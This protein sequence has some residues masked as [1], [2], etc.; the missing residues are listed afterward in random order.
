[1][2]SLNINGLRSHIDEI[3]LLLNELEIDILAL[4]ETKLGDSINRQKT[5]I[6]GF[7]EVRLDRSRQGG[8]V[9]LYLRDSIQYILRNDIPNSNLELLCIEVQP[10]K[11]SSS[12]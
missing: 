5:E 1:M 11:A 6:A 3:K 12:F 7:K 2:A 8:G 4:N 9:S 10:I